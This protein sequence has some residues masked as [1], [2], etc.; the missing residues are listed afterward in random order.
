[1]ATSNTTIYSVNTLHH[2][3]SILLP[4][5][6]VC[7]EHD[8][9]L[10]AESTLNMLWTYVKCQTIGALYEYISL[11]A[12]PSELFFIGIVHECT[13]QNKYPYTKWSWPPNNDTPN[14][15]CFIYTLQFMCWYYKCFTYYLKNNTKKTD[16]S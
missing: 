5:S 8:I 7:T 16:I 11:S 10:W 3:Q 14:T 15:V 1:M 6:G 4:L 13:G 9:V 12:D 2:V